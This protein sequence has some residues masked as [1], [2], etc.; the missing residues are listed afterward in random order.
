MS[1]H[2]TAPGPREIS[3]FCQMI[4]SNWNS[5]KVRERRQRAKSKQQELVRCLGTGHANGQHSG[6]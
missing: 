4:R 6:K 5:S 3:N 2:N 1:H